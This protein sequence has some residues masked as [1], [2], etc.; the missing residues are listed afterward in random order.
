MRERPEAGEHVGP[1]VPM[2]ADWAAAALARAGELAGRGRHAAAE[3]VLKAASGSLARRG[4]GAEAARL[5]LAIG[6]IRLTR[7][8]R[9]EACAAFEAGRRLFDEAGRREDAVR[10]V[11]HRGAALVDDG[12]LANA[13]AL[14]RAAGTEARA[15]GLDGLARAAGLLLAKCLYWA[16]RLAAARDSS[17]ALQPDACARARAP[18]AVAER[19]DE[20]AG[21][22]ASGSVAALPAGLPAGVSVIAAEIGVRAALD[23]GDT[24]R[25]ARTLA[26]AGDWRDAEEPGE[27]ATLCGLAVLVRGALGDV[28]TAQ[29]EFREGLARLRALHA[30]ASAIELR[31]THIEALIDAGSR[32]GALSHLRRV[33]GRPSP[34][35][36]GLVRARLEDLAARLSRMPDEPVCRTPH[37][38]CE[39]VVRIL[40]QC[41]DADDDRGAVAGVCRTVRAALDAASVSALYLNGN[42]PAIVANAGGRPCRPA[43]AVRA[44]TAPTAIGPDADASGWEAAA[45]I[46]H[47]GRPLG[48]LAARWAPEGA[49]DPARTRG[50]LA[51]AAAAIAPAFAAIAAS[52]VRAVQAGS[53]AD[54]LAGASETMAALRARIARAAAAPFPVLIQ[55]ESGTGK[56]LIAKAIHA[57]SARR[58]GRYC[59]V[60]CAALS[61]DLFESELFGH[62][63]GAFTGASSDRQGLFEEADGGT[64]FLDEIAELSPRAQAKLLRAI[65]EGEIRR[66]G[67]NRARRVDA[68]I[69]SASN[70][71][72]ADEARE[73]RFRTD[74]LFRLDVIRISVPPL[75][76]RRE[77]IVP[78]ARRFWREATGR[79]GV[80]AELTHAALAALARYDWPGNVRELQNTLAALAVHAPP[81]G[82]VGPASLPQAV[83]EAAAGLPD[84]AVTLAVAR[85]RFEEGYVRTALA[86]VGGCRSEAAAALGLTRQGLA[87]LMGRLGIDAG[88]GED[89]AY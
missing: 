49:P 5:Q 32:A 6:R 85:R 61:D 1:T 24:A 77:D 41:Q 69:V 54:E 34:L 21:A 35:A 52:G 74:L 33:S 23:A 46:Q 25:A 27:A 72:L 26:A 70:R 28:P 2:A 56:E 38:E 43:F 40:R 57:G 81:R 37:V 84:T 47:G 4:L 73:G 71:S 14:L 68:R 17:S 87:K 79:V 30:P 66:I 58:Q 9:R 75:R 59:A 51:A 15:R 19:D 3:R 45:P 8:R 20:S 13:E 76:E 63:R 89:A 36:T 60:N 7:G 31:A 22:S 67:E 12:D 18:E 16:G 86:R 39:A 88:A 50:V 55:G 42:S 10:A 64:L 62:V 83:S 48:A 80:R 78:L 44:A 11:L 53:D 65:Q 29:R 82:R